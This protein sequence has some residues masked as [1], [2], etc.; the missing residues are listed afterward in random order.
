MR[1]EE[2]LLCVPVRERRIESPGAVSLVVNK[3]QLSFAEINSLRN[4]ML[5]ADYLISRPRH[6]LSS[7]G[8]VIEY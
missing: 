3:F 7:I 4:R 2:N 5:T 8:N 6:N 1:R